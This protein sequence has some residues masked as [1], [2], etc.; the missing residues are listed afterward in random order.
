MSWISD[1]FEKAAL[2]GAVIVTLALGAVVYKNK[3][4]L[5]EA[6][7][8]DAPKPNKS[9]GVPGLKGMIAVKGSLGAVHE[10]HQADVDGR[11][12]DLFT[13]VSLFSK[14]DDPKNPVDL[15]KSD[16]VHPGIDNTWWLKNGIDPGYSDSPERDPDKDGFTNREEFVAGTDPNEFK[17]FPEPVVKLNVV[18][19]SATQVHVKPQDYGAGNFKF[20]LQN[21][22]E[23]DLNKMPNLAKPIQAGDNI[24]F[25]KDLMKN[26]FKFN[27]V[28]ETEVDKN[29]FKQKVKWWEIEDLKPNKQGDTY[30]F[31]RRGALKGHEDRKV[32]IMDSTV[33][34]ALQALGQGGNPFEVEENTPF[35]LPF[36]PKA[37]EKPYL[38]KSVDLDAK[39]VEVEYTA[40]DGTK[41]LHVMPFK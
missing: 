39:K 15:L 28:V 8:K 24:V 32:G 26:R 19:V 29:G 21:K 38:L 17:N 20:K 25:E 2:G 12:V 34:L 13:G 14:K 10:V 33:K 5:A 30:L 3:G 40:K 35:S 1:N 18:S 6:F 16:P 7:T 11:K 9:T 36:D 23:G 37:A 22:F 4:D 31:D 27:K 41:K